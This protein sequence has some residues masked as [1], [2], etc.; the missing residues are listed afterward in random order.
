M[1]AGAVIR[2]GAEKTRNAGGGAFDDT[3]ERRGDARYDRE[4]RGDDNGEPAGVLD[5]QVLG[6]DFADNHV[7]VG[8]DGEGEDEAESVEKGGTGRGEQRVKD[9]EQDL[10]KGVFAGP[11]EA[12]T[13]Q[14]HADLSY[15]E[16]LFRMREESKGHT[17]AGVT[18]FGEVAEAR[19]S[20][21]QEGH[22]GGREEGIHHKDESQ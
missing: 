1:A 14:G 6:D 21:R 10:V 13:G 3:D 9:V 5:G 16:K 4:D 19:V 15:G 11:A 22:F 8:H 2:A 17:G 20:H 12:E 18:F 7:A